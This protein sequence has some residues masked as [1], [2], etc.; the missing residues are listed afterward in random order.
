LRRVECDTRH[1]PAL[2]I[3]HPDV[4]ALISVPMDGDSLSILGQIDTVVLCRW[5]HCADR[6]PCAVN[7]RQLQIITG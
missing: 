7:P 1:H 3:C 4:A 6:F 2:G 5:A